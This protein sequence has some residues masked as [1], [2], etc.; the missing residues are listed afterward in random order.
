MTMSV[1]LGVSIETEEDGSHAVE[2]SV[3]LSGTLQEE[4][5]TKE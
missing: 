5:G 4:I 2:A 1:E 3:E